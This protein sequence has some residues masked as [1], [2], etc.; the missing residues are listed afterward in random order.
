M[1]SITDMHSTHTR[2]GT[3]HVTTHPTRAPRSTLHT[4]SAPRALRYT[5]HAHPAFYATHP[6]RTQRSTLH[7]PRAPRAQRAPAH[8]ITAGIITGVHVL[9][10]MHAVQRVSLTRHNQRDQR[11]QCARRA[12]LAHLAQRSF[13]THSLSHREVVLDSL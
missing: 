12:H 2:G 3:P 11:G 4:P 13:N 5:P 10:C 7:T 9:C 1:A 6:T 8:R